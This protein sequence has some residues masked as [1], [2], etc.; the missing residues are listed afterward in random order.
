[1]P[2][3]DYEMI[4]LVKGL[5]AQEAQNNYHPKVLRAK[6]KA[7]ALAAANLSSDIAKRELKSQLQNA[8][9]V[10]TEDPDQMTLP[11]GE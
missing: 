6:Y 10:P 9:S 4:E 7:F 1:M 3:L 5:A 2:T 11:T 8:V